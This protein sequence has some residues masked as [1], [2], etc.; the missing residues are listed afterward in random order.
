MWYIGDELVGLL[1]GCWVEIIEMIGCIGDVCC[2]CFVL[3]FVKFWI[4]LVFVFCCFDEGEGDVGFFG[5]FLV[6]LFVVF[7]NVDFVDWMFV[8]VVCVEIL[9]VVVFEFGGYGSGFY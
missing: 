9:W 4:D 8:W 6:Y 1:I 2:F 3:E 5:C 7:G